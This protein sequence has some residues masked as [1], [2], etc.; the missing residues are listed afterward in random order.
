MR[1]L[2]EIAEKLLHKPVSRMNLDSGIFEPADNEGTYAEALSR[3]G[4]F[5]TK[6]G[7]F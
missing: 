3:S 1:N 2:V 7:I 4:I 6:E 5:K